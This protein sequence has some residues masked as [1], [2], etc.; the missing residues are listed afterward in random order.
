V[1]GIRLICI[2]RWGIGRTPVATY[3]RSYSLWAGIVEEVLDQLEVTDFDIIGHSAGSPY[4][5][6]TALRCTTRVKG[7]HL[8][9]PWLS[10]SHESLAGA[11][12]L[13]AYMP[14]SVLRTGTLCVH[15]PSSESDSNE[16]FANQQHNQPNGNWRIGV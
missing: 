11:Y 14:S 3:E 15:P 12:K 1:L 16:R 6:A 2:D 4:A 7:V 10:K 13:L 9:A 8:L 5:L